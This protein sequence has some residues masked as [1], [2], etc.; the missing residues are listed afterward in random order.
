MSAPAPLT[1]E[2]TETRLWQRLSG[3]IAALEHELA[4]E[5]RL[6]V[7]LADDSQAHLD[8]ALAAEADLARLRG[9]VGEETSDA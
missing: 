9:I 1:P 3:R 7:Q 5:R 2:G 8:R 6:R 4:I